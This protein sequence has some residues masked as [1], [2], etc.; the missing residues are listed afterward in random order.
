MV[1]EQEVDLRNYLRGI[2]KVLVKNWMWIIGVT[3]ICAVLS[4]LH[5]RNLPDA[6]ISKALIDPAKIQKVVVENSESLKVLFKN[7]INPYLTEIAKRLGLKEEE[8]LG[9]VK[10]F[11]IMDK[12][13]YLE[14]ETIG[15]TPEYAKKLA[16]LVCELVLER[17]N[18]LMQNALK[19]IEDEIPL[20]EEQIISAQKEVKSLDKKIL[21][22][23]KTDS[24]A[25]SY[26]YQSLIS[27]KENARKREEDLRSRLSSIKMELK[28]YTK[29]ATIVAEPC[30]LKDKIPANKLQSLFITVGICFGIM[31]FLVT[32]VNYFKQ[33]SSGK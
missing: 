1:E 21:Q 29:P 19:I 4:F 2:W 30:L 20:I 27:S 26:V 3:F 25:Q 5:L 24:L 6:Y 31:I 28:Y 33:D 32:M 13:G 23:E 9:L 18:R 12:A 7:P 11:K 10:S 17:Q 8:G 15:K 14:I 16:D 22:K